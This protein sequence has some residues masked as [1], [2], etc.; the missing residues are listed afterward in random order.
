M[1][2]KSIPFF[3]KAVNLGFG[4]IF[5]AII[6]IALVSLGRLTGSCHR[7]APFMLAVLFLLA[8]L[9]CFLT[10][11]LESLFARQIRA[12]R[13]FEKIVFA[14]MLLFLILAQTAFVLCFDLTPKNDLKHLCTAAENYVRGGLP[15]LYDG[16]PTRHQH[17]FAVYPNNH[18]LFLL[19]VA[20][21][22]IS[23]ALTGQC[24]LLL[25]TLW[26]LLGLDLSYALMY[27]CAH[28]LYPPQKALLCGL[29][30]LLFLPII[31][32]TL[33]FYTDA[34]ALPWVTLAFY[35]YLQWRT[36]TEGGKSGL[37]RF[38]LPVACGLVLGVAYSFKGSAGILLPAFALDL[39]LRRIRWRDRLLPLSAIT[40]SFLLCIRLLSALSAGVLGFSSEELSLYR[41]PLIHWIMMGADG[42]GGYQLEDFLYTGSFPGFHNKIRADLL[43]L[44]QKLHDQGVPGFLHHLLCKIGY[45]WRDGTY[46]TGYYMPET[47]LFRKLPFLIYATLAHFTLLLSMTRS[48]LTKRKLADD[49]LSASFVLKII[50]MGLV[51]FL[52]LWEARCRYLVSFFFLFAL[53]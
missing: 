16:L 40:L 22:R 6:L 38:L 51:V 31:T 8:L 24:S 18:L 33:Y 3:S 13:H 30:G 26:N 48:F 17:Y 53:L 1:P 32:Y 14:G 36:K 23:V 11:R 47:L 21:Q 15:H 12:S 20:L 52:L 19:L 9:F 49:A 29:R 25:P 27:G 7:L 45:T 28:L 35:L 37:F 39:L 4:S 42:N 34:M 41:F 2:K 5:A 43:R 10:E 50:L 46:M 44:G